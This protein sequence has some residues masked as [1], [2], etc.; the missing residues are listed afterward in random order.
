MDRQPRKGLVWGGGLEYNWGRVGRA[1]WDVAAGCS[2]RQEPG[3]GGLG[4]HPPAPM[5]YTGV[6][7]GLGRGTSQMCVKKLKGL[8]LVAQWLRICLPMLGT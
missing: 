1:H 4:P 6:P 8:L 5:L 3:H 7:R 2:D